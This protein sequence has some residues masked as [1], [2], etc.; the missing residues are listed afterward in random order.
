MKGIMGLGVE[1]PEKVLGNAEVVER[2]NSS[3]NKKTS[4]EWIWEHIGIRERRQIA[5]N[6]TTSDLALRASQKAI[7]NAGINKEDISLI[8]MNT[9]SP[10]YPYTPPTACILQYKLGIKNNCPAFDMPTACAGFSYML[11]IAANMKGNVLIVSADAITRFIDWSDRNTCAYFGDG[12]GA[13]IIGNDGKHKILGGFLGADGSGWD[14][15]IYPVGGAANK[16]TKE[17]LHKMNLYMNGAAV[18]EFAVPKLAECLKKLEKEYG[19]IDFV[20]PHQANYN[21]IKRGLELAGYPM[22]KTHTILHKWGNQVGSTIPIA[23]YDAV[24][25]GKIKKGM[26]VALV[27]FGAGLA[28]GAH[29]IE[30]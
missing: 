12:A 1:I 21:I 28:W 6:E 22:D 3:S 11:E 15:L 14:V 2:V 13:A 23:L 25:E 5:D 24:Q 20:I 29:V 19:T 10:D 16:C 27:G 17:N 7:E 18:Y 4:D 9:I 26:K 30:W 8:L